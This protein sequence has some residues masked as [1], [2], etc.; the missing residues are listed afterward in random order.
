MS[1]G[2]VVVSIVALMPFI[3]M[4]VVAGLV[5]YLLS[6]WVIRTRAA[7]HQQRLEMVMAERRALIDRGVTDLP[8]LNPSIPRAGRGYA[9]IAWGVVLL[10]LA[11]AFVAVAVFLPSTPVFGHPAT[12]V[13]SGALGAGLVLAHFVV[14]HYERIDAER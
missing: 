10:T 5:V 7:I 1:T 2:E 12:A 13:L 8:P 11:A 3:V 4:A 9:T 14:R 6:L